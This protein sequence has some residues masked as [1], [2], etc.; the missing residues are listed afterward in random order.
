[1]ADRGSAEETCFKIVR[2]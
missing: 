1:M 2:F